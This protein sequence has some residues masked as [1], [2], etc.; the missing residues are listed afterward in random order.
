MGPQQNGDSSVNICTLKILFLQIPLSV[1]VR[2]QYKYLIAD[3]RF[4]VR[5]SIGKMQKNA[6]L[7]GAVNVKIHPQ[8]NG[9]S[10]VNIRTLTMLFFQMPSFISARMWY[11]YLLVDRRIRIRTSI[12]KM[13]KNA[14]LK[15]ALNLKECPH[16]NGDRSVTIS[17]LETII[18]PL[19]LYM[20]II[21]QYK[22]LITD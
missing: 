7:K 3:Q 10:S 8:Q 9:D 20:C 11:H 19:T 21:L 1:C 18:S 12:R 4:K 13:Q 6:I 17:T 16:Q 22:Y 2:L 14:I 5:T 15:G